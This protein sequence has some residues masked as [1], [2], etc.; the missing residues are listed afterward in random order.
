[1]AER[2]KRET[3][4]IRRER[5]DYDRRQNKRIPSIF[6]IPVRSNGYASLA[7]VKTLSAERAPLLHHP[8]DGCDTGRQNPEETTDNA[9]EMNCVKCKI[10]LSLK[11]GTER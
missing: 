8:S 1:M 4:R 11:K 6:S 3:E 9:A 5:E 7:A 2:R 10:I